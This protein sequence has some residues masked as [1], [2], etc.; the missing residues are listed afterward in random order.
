MIPPPDSPR[1]GRLARTVAPTLGLCALLVAVSIAYGNPP[2]ARRQPAPPS[3]PVPAK[4]RSQAADESA[5]DIAFVPLLGHWE[6][7]SEDGVALITGDATRWDGA[8]PADQS[9]LAAGVGSRR[10]E[11]GTWYPL[12]LTIEGRS[13]RAVAAGEL[14]I[15]YTLDE[16]VQGRV[17][18]WT[19]RDSITSF[20]D[21]RAR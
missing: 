17:G 16:P 18:L 1:V 19:K 9:A 5:G 4:P 2:P 14:T 20:R 7:S 10:L 8:P 11:L 13:L 12:E 6:V 15:E 3:P 21:L